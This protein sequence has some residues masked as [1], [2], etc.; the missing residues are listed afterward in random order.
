MRNVFSGVVACVAAAALS[1]LLGAVASARPLTPAEQRY[2]R[3]QGVVPLC[4]NPDVADTISSR[5]SQREGGYW[6][7]GLAIKAFEDI[8]E[9][10]YRSN[11]VDYIPRRYC[12]ATVVTTDDR[13]RKLFY[14]TAEDLGMTGTD[15]VGSLA[16]SLTLGLAIHSLPVSTA[17]NYGVDWCVVGLDRNG[18]YGKDCRSARP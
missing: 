13:R 14:T 2:A 15:I 16:Q 1:C 8:R 18:A 10:G 12:A 9:I 6:D 17:T 5:F 3:W 11:G 7:S 4:E